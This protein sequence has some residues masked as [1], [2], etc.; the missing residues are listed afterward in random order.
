MA[1]PH[2]FL[3]LFAAALIAAIALAPAP[4]LAGLLLDRLKARQSERQTPK[5]APSGA[6]ILRDIAYGSDS[7]ETLDV[8]LPPSK[9]SGAPLIFMVHGGGWRIGDKGHDKVVNNKTAR[10]LPRGFIFISI[11]YP[12]LPQADP[13]HQA[14]SVA[15]ALAYAQRHAAEWGGDGARFVL[16]GH[17]AGAHLVALLNAN[18]ALAQ[19]AQP[20]LGT[21]SLDSGAL[22]VAPIMKA[23][24]LA[25]YD[26]AFGKDE[27]FWRRASPLQILTPLAP[28]LL[29]VCSSRRTDSCPQAEALARK[30]KNLGALAS[31]LPENL[32]H[33]EINE[34][35]G[36]SNA[37]TES[38]E[39]FMASLDPHIKV[40]L[41]RDR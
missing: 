15:R 8:Y 11:N 6:T 5:P 7:R 21:I 4:T 30:A 33:S 40:L 24:H 26:D 34:T 27:D 25:L 12:M 16:M 10:W 29:M 17:S 39:A 23:R 35:L 32:S 38:V 28:P 3:P 1:A 36:L 18:P 2:R 20:W 14:D 31:V 37:Y 13:L 19:G 22:D 9:T 41:P